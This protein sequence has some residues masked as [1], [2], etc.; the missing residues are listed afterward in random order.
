MKAIEIWNNFLADK[1]QLSD[2]DEL[3]FVREGL[4]EWLLKYLQEFSFGEKAELLLIKSR[5]FPVVLDYI[6]FS[7]EP[8]FIQSEK[9]LLERKDTEL[10]LKYAHKFCFVQELHPFMVE[11]S[12]DDVLLGYFLEEELSSD[13]EI[14]LIERY[15]EKLF[16]AYVEEYVLTENAEHFLIEQKKYDFFRIYVSEHNRIAQS[17][18]TLLANSHDEKMLDIF[19]EFC[20]C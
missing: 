14:K 5:S 18:L 9:A 17:S 1:Q 2:D 3:I 13:G 7:D 8:F 12:S 4:D 11:N 15:S 19:R 20:L 10:I 16:K 6:Y